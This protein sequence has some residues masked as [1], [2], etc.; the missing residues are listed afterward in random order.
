MLQRRGT[1]AFD[2]FAARALTC[3]SIVERVAA[4]MNVAVFSFYHYILPMARLNLIS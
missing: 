2:V 4:S 1:Y 3:R